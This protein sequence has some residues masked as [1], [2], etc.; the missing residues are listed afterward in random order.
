MSK[1]SLSK[2]LLGSS[3]EQPALPNPQQPIIPEIQARVDPPKPAPE[4]APATT[5][6][7]DQG[8][9]LSGWSDGSASAEDSLPQQNQEQG[10]NHNEINNFDPLYYD[11]EL[12]LNELY[13][14]YDADDFDGGGM[15]SENEEEQEEEEEQ[16]DSAADDDGNDE[17]VVDLCDSPEQSPSPQQLDSSNNDDEIEI[18]ENE[19]TESTATEQ[20]E[21]EEQQQQEQHR[22]CQV[23]GIELSSM[24]YLQQVHHVKQ[25]LS[26]RHLQ[27]PSKPTPVATTTATATA[28]RKFLEMDIKDWLLELGFATCIDKFISEEIDMTLVHALNED[29]LQLLGISNLLDQRKFLRAAKKVGEE[30]QARKRAKRAAAAAE[31]MNNSKQKGIAL[32]QQQQQRKKQQTLQAVGGVSATTAT[33][34]KNQNKPNNNN[35]D[36]ASNRNSIQLAEQAL[37]LNLYPSTKNRKKMNS[38][39]VVTAAP[40]DSRLPSTS[41]ATIP[42]VYNNDNAHDSLPLPTPPLPPTT[43]LASARVPCSI[44]LFTSAAHCKQ[45]T[46]TLESR[47]EKRRAERPLGNGGT[48]NEELGRGGLTFSKVEESRALKAMKLQALKE[49]LRTHENTV[50]ELK[51][52]IEGLE[53]ELG[54]PQK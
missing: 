50:I 53:T 32:M 22:V 48:G 9:P 47:I 1:L 33:N 25:C 39:Y 8:S 44:S 51:K 42:V 28:K 37:L 40:A 14:T 19:K 18:L 4:V 45:V 30:I 23:C 5:T 12:P 10:P 16:D 46:E 7:Q 3:E 38:R 36:D 6:A 20:E 31:K 11:E 49:E 43:A 35:N 26:K 24:H 13:D 29:D 21:E 34:L 41:A 2:R 54:Q 27:G 52:L 15:F 17:D